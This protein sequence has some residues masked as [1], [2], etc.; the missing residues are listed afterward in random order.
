MLDYDYIVANTKYVARFTNGRRETGNAKEIKKYYNRSDVKD[1]DAVCWEG[2]PKELQAFYKA[3]NRANY[4]LGLDLFLV[5]DFYE[6]WI[7]DPKQFEAEY[8]EVIGQLSEK[9]S[10][11]DI[12]SDVIIENYDGQTLGNHIVGNF[13]EALDDMYMDFDVIQL[14]EKHGYTTIIIQ[15]D[16]VDKIR[17][18]SLRANKNAI[19]HDRYMGDGKY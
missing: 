11:L 12:K 3:Y 6:E 17:D 8:H 4:V 10:D 15:D 16:N 13:K 5:E 19:A 2:Q 14:L 7:K 9:L 1:I 18:L